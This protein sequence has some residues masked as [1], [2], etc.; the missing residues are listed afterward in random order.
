V[1]SQS[2][3]N[4]RPHLL[5]DVTPTLSVKT[6]NGIE[7]QRGQVIGAIRDRAPYSLTQTGAISEMGIRHYITYNTDH[8]AKNDIV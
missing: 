7:R 4:T 2:N 6:V 5:S 8:E 3:G 1:I